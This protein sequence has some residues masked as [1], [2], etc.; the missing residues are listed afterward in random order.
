MKAKKLTLSCL[1]AQL[2]IGIHISS[3][4]AEEITNFPVTQRDAAGIGKIEQGSISLPSPDIAK[5]VWIGFMAKDGVSRETTNRLQEVLEKT[6]YRVTNNKDL[7]NIKITVSGFA[8]IR[9]ELQNSFDTGSVL[10][11]DITPSLQMDTIVYGN[12]T[13]EYHPDR[14]A[15]AGIINGANQAITQSGGS[16]SGGLAGL[17]VAV[18]INLLRDIFESSPEVKNKPFQNIVGDK[19]D[20]PLICFDACRKTHHEVVLNI[21]MTSADNPDVNANYSL[22]VDKLSTS[23]DEKAMNSLAN[24]SFELATKHLG[25]K[26]TS[27]PG[28]QHE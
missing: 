23:V 24:L 10:I 14:S 28:V 16:T 12:S 15:D 19:G 22:Y 6:G 1:L 7:A 18:G 13:T 21:A 4:S 5:K 17:G 26:Q 8:R 3:L 25:A 27:S 20:R 9:N 2:I 11:K